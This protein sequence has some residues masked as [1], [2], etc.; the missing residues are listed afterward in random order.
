MRFLLGAL[1]VFAT[2]IQVP[3]LA[4]RSFGQESLATVASSVP[5]PSL[6]RNTEDSL[7]SFPLSQIRI[8]EGVFRDSIEINLRVLREIGVERALYAFRFQAGLPTAD[9]KPLRGWASPEPY[10]AF[11]GFFEGHFLSALA[12][13]ASQSDD[14]ALK[15][16]V[17]YM[18]QELARCQKALGGKYLFASPEIEFEPDRLD[19]VVWYRMH[20]L[21]EGLLAAYEHVGCDE[22]LDVAVR[23]AAWIDQRMESYGDRWAKVKSIEFG[24]M[25]E[26]LEGL[27]QFTGNPRFHELALRWEEPERIL[28]PFAEGKDFNEHANTLLAK[29]VGASRI[30]EVS[31][32]QLHR[33][34][35]AGFWNK[36]AGAGRKTYAT[37]GTSVHEGMP[38]AGRLAN[39]QSRMPQE[40]CVSYNLLKVT[41]AMFRLT[42]ESSYID[43]YERVLWN[44]I[45]G[46]Q[47]PVTGWKSYY[48]PLNANTV[49]DFRSHE[50]GCYCCNGTGL[51]NP[52]R[53]ASMIYSHTNEEIFVNLFIA[54]SVRWPAKK[55]TLEQKTSFP[56]EDRGTL[57]I[58]GDAPTD[59]TLALRVPSWCGDS[60]KIWVNGELNQDNP[61]KGSFIRMHRTWKP[62]DRVEFQFPLPF[63]FYPMPD[64]PKQVALMVGP[65]VLVGVGARE[66]LGELVGDLENPSSKLCQLDMWLKRVSNESLDFVGVDDASREILFRPYYQIGAD[67]FFTGYWDL[68][69]EP[70]P[71]SGPRN[72]ALGKKTQCST[73]IPEGSNLECFMRSAKAVDGQYGG[74]DDWY[75]KWFPNGMSPQWLIVDL[76]EA[77]D[78]DAIEWVP[79]REDS[80]AMLAYRYR[81]EV[82]SNGKDWQEVADASDNDLA[83]NSYR[84]E[85]TI[86]GR[87]VRLTT[88][89]NPKLKD[90]QAR[91][92]IAELMVF[93]K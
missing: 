36:V 64:D 91:P 39:T 10:G 53:Y 52:A 50:I 84:H 20:K 57:L 92:K 34:A 23:V 59:F 7:V 71:R 25:A 49:K 60:P 55:I 29:M 44:S 51:E 18:V 85:V 90:H 8:S 80:D 21:L 72:L 13:H 3:V 62:G 42:H 17:F 16:E 15:R 82:S 5:N 88:L 63:S 69:P 9:A 87:Y 79:A 43:Y 77:H 41:Q 33:D 54:S 4:A 56:R 47:D 75:V 48:Q 28:T 81:V 70:K 73:P 46:S 66:F 14:G 86:S 89:P 1:L 58:A 22:A 26:S 61:T 37:G 67:Q 24:G 2:F 30:A 27:F 76:E 93:G 40:T 68:V 74:A 35:T 12:M 65:I 31:H 6:G 19:G 78:I 11:P 83:N 45:L 32:S 38:P